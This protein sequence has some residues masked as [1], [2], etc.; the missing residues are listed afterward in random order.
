MASC[1]GRVAVDESSGCDELE[2]ATKGGAV[3]AA[4]VGTAVE[5]D[6]P[7]MKLPD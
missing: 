2:L 1:C 7:L 4:I 5:L 6:A 3:D